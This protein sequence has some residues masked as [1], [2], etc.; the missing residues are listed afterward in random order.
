MANWC[1]VII[2]I[3][4]KDIAGQQAVYTDLK[5]TID[6]ES[7]APELLGAWFITG[8]RYTVFM[9]GEVK[10]SLDEEDVKSFIRRITKVADIA[11]VDID[12]EEIG[13]QLYG[14]YAYS[15]GVLKHLFVDPDKFPG[16]EDAS[17]YSKL[18]DMLT[19]DPVEVIINIDADKE[20][21]DDIKAWREARKALKG[22]M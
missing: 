22:V 17:L 6:S 9:E 14:R 20:S 16:D 12:Y 13:Y 11:S 18:D 5:T 8:N 21:E 1:S 4:C 19:N 10:W 15:D 2:D 3:T 7:D